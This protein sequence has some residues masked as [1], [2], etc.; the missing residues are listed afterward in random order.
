MSQKKFEITEAFQGERIDL[1]LGTLTDFTRNQLQQFLKEGLVQVNGKVVKKSYLC[2]VGDK[3]MMEVIEKEPTELEGENLPLEILYE[4]DRFAI[5]NKERGVVV[6]PAPGHPDGTLVNALL[7]HMNSL[8]NEKDTIRPGIVHRMDK[9]T[10]GVLLIT[11]TNE[12]HEYFSRLFKAHDLKRCYVAIVE[13]VIK[14]DEIVV[15][16]AIARSETNRK[17]FTVDPSGRYAKT[18]VEVI[19]RFQNYTLVRCTLFT[20]RTHQI[21]VHLKYLNHPIVGDPVYGMKKS[22]IKKDGQYLHAIELG[23]TDENGKSYDFSV[24]PPEYFQSFLQKMRQV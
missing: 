17:A 12:A 18:L 9:D 20:G 5:V 8:S 13:G 1:V 3:V 19:E 4:N 22:K 21:R 11:K 16:E 7:Y 2:E 23:F 6:H 10:S 24:D 14:E 15:E